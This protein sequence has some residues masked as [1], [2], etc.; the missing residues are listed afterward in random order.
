[1]RV[2]AV[3]LVD[4][5]HGREGGGIGVGEQLPRRPELAPLRCPEGQDVEHDDLGLVI[6]G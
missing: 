6:A 3:D 1:M 2:E 4:D 5:G